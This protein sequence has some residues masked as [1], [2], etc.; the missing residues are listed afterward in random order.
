MKVS[1]VSMSLLCLALGAGCA[2]VERNTA[3]LDE[4]LDAITRVW[5]GEFG[6]EA[7]AVVLDAI[8]V[9]PAASAPGV[10]SALMQ[11]L[12]EAVRARGGR[13]IRTQARQIGPAGFEDFLHL[14][15]IHQGE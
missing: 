3:R 10:G 11:G 2:S 5:S 9:D 12:V 7:P 13:E 14:G 15:N 4:D 1:T 6:G 8:A